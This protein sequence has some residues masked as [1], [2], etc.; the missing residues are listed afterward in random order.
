[1]IRSIQ[2]QTI[3]DKAPWNRNRLVVV[4]R[5]KLYC[6][7][8]FLLSISDSFFYLT[9]L[10]LYLCTSH[11]TSHVLFVCFLRWLALLFLILLYPHSRTVSNLWTVQPKR[12]TFSR[13]LS[14]GKYCTIYTR[15]ST[16]RYICSRVLWWNALSFL[17]A[18]NQRYSN[19]FN[20]Y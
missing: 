7:F 5:K 1:M 4:S 19:T 18:T 20:T 14:S 2:I 17:C 15:S 13:A 6:R 3:N 16:T 8:S 9:K 12:R 10:E 11:G